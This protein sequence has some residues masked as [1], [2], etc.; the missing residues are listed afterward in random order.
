MINLSVKPDS[1]DGD[2]VGLLQSS[3]SKGRDTNFGNLTVKG[4][5][6]IDDFETLRVRWEILP[7]T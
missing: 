2:E 1:G 4:F 7:V 5:R 6:T 3:R